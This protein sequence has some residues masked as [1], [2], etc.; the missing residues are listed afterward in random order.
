ME[1]TQT[2]FKKPRLLIV[3]SGDVGQRCI[4]LLRD[5]FH[6]YAV[7]RDPQQ[8]Q[9]LRAL[10]AHAILADLDHRPSLRRLTALAHTVVHLAPPNADGVIDQRTRNLIAILPDKSRLV[11]ISTSG[12]YGD[13]AGAWVDET[14]SVAP[15]NARAVR[16]VDAE[17]SLRAWALRSQSQL[18]ILR[19]PGIYAEDRL[20]IERLK[21]GT[22]ALIESDDVFT[23][24]IHADDLAYLI[25]LAL[26]RAKSNRVYHAVDQTQLKMADYFDLVATYFDFPR[27]P[28]LARVE[29]EKQISPVLLSF[30][31]ESRRL[32]SGRVRHELRARLT[33]PDVALALEKMKAA[34]LTF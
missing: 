6:I 4:R 24:H 23:N 3:G 14:R 31:S 1:S 18:S 11:Y 27:P 33:Y 32:S 21:K 12:V 9:H 22:P 10:G 29:L 2:K 5:R 28:R 26:F 30:M 25:Q 17:C 15:K 8:V 16:R 13:C 34:G 20:P 7:T 19:V